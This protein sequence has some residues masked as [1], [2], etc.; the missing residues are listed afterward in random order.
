MEIE[1]TTSQQLIVKVYA[2]DPKASYGCYPI[3][4]RKTSK[5]NKTKTKNPNPNQTKQTDSIYLQAQHSRGRS[6]RIV[7]LEPI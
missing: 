1:A 7:N 4:K 2:N 5:Q 3:P 6:S